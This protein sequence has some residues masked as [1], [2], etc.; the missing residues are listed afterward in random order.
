MAILSDPEYSAEAHGVGEAEVV[1]EVHGDVDLVS[2]PALMSLTAEVARWGPERLVFDLSDVGIFG[3]QGVNAIV[4]AR[5]LLFG[6]FDL[7]VRHPGPLTRQVLEITKAGE[8]CT[9]EE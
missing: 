2:S 5:R 8:I 9:I 6:E 4:V 1:I 3:S 7:V